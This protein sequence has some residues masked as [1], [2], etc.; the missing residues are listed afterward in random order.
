MPIL[1]LPIAVE[2][3]LVEVLVGLTPADL[4]ALRQAGQTPPPEQRLRALID[5]G[6]SQSCI[7]F[8]CVTALGLVPAGQLS[9]LIP[10]VGGGSQTYDLHTVSV[11]LLHPQAN[12][13][14][15]VVDVVAANRASQGVEML[16]GRDV[17]KYCT[18]FYDG[19]A[20]TFSLAF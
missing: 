20:N 12:Y 3:P 18:L 7:D 9:L 14:L 16:L 1:T 19:P 10:S 2:G 5:T 13:Y 6:A 4:R 11:T 8:G 17:L 15:P